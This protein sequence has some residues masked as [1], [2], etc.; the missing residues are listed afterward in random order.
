M[1]NSL[2]KFHHIP[3]TQSPKQKLV[4][5][6]YIFNVFEKKFWNYNDLEVVYKSKCIWEFY[7]KAFCFSASS[8]DS[9]I[10]I[11]PGA[12]L[13]TFDLRMALWLFN[14]ILTAQ[15]GEQWGTRSQ[16]VLTYSF[17]RQHFNNSNSYTLLFMQSII[18]GNSFAAF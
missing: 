14:R 2:G 13:Q 1:R 12:S 15:K 3:L 5:D 10:T 8:H 11:I 4:S 9:L 16:C 18:H 17:K 7:T 6:L